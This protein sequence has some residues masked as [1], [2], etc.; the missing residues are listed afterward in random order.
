MF[1]KMLLSVQC[2][3]NMAFR[4]WFEDPWPHPRSKL[5]NILQS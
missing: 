2:N 1:F 3:K 4:H 5:S